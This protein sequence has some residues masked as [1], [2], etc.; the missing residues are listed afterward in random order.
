MLLRKFTCARSVATVGAASLAPA[1]LRSTVHSQQLTAP[2]AVFLSGVAAVVASQRRLAS[3]SSCPGQCGMSGFTDVKYNTAADHW[4]DETCDVIDAL[5]E[6]YPV[7]S[8]VGNNGGVLTLDLGEEL[9]TFILNKQAPKRQLWLSSPISGPS[10]Y[11]MIDGDA[12]GRVWW[13][14]DKTGAD[15]SKLLET[16]LMSL[17]KG[18]SIQLP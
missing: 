16:E 3:S 15:L 2:S 13:K 11:D 1:M 17:L 14:C 7:I 12:E 9:G 18:S 10:H 4:L 5:C 6:D 8:D